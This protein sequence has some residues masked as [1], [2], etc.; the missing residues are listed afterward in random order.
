LEI[1]ADVR[2]D[3]ALKNIVKEHAVE[4][5]LLEEAYISSRYAVTDFREDEVLRVKK[6]FDEVLKHV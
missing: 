6:A 2:K 3:E 1:L 4:L 5:R